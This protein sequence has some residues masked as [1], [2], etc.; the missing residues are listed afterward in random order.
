MPLISRNLS[1]NN[2]S[3]FLT[4]DLIQRSFLHVVSHFSLLASVVEK[5]ERE[6]NS[7]SSKRVATSLPSPTAKPW[8]RTPCLD[9]GRGQWE[10]ARHSTWCA[11]TSRGTAW[12][13]PD[14]IDQ[15]RMWKCERMREFFCVANV[16]KSLFMRHR[17]FSGKK[18][19]PWGRSGV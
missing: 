3:S 19:S 2:I 14:G 12:P 1:N 5:G 11:T 16:Y 7:Q 4:P 15:P 9:A 10:E 13:S 6:K 18:K 17:C 8:H